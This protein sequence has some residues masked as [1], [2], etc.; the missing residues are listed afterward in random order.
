MVDAGGARYGLPVAEAADVARRI[1]DL[2]LAGDLSA[3][4]VDLQ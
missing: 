1:V 2:L 3:V 4:E